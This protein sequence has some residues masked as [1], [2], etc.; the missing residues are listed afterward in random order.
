[1][2]KITNEMMEKAKKAASA[3]ELLEI[4]KAE[5]VE[6]SASDAEMYFNF[7]SGSREL[8]NEELSQVAG[9]KGDG[10]PL[11]KYKINQRVSI[12]LASTK[13]T[14][15]GTIIGINS[16]RSCGKLVYSYRINV[17]EYGSAITLNLEN[18]SKGDVQVI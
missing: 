15:H 14:I 1:M 3:E 2:E 18:F 17:E 11:P 7:L 10:D 8:T 13:N 12:Y 16:F 9:G 4:A 6:L 5:G